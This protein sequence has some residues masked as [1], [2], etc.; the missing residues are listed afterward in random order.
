MSNPLDVQQTL[1]VQQ[2]LDHCM[3]TMKSASKA[4]A[5]NM[6][7]VAMRLGTA[8]MMLASASNA[9]HR[10]VAQRAQPDTG[11]ELSADGSYG[12]QPCF[13]GLMAGAGRCRPCSEAGFG[14]AIPAAAPDEELEG[15][16]MVTAASALFRQLPVDQLRRLAFPYDP[17]AP[18]GR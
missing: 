18:K 7:D 9:V 3:Q 2:A 16:Q 14:C 5:D 15:L 13:H 11:E 10:R 17:D 4:M 12:T 8:A 6:H 1:D